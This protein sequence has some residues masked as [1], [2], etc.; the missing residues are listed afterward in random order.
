MNPTSEN[1]K[2]IFFQN[3]TRGKWTVELGLVGKVQYREGPWFREGHIEFTVSGSTESLKELVN[4]S[5]KN[6]ATILFT[7][8]RYN[9]R[10]SIEADI[11]EI[12]IVRTPIDIANVQ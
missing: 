1:R 8:L 4:N 11:L 12:N 2:E 6:Q 10:N 5:N 7:N 9:N 3:S